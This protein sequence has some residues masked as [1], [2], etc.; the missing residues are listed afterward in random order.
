MGREILE[1]A[2]DSLFVD[3]SHRDFNAADTK[4]LKKTCPYSKQKA[5]R[6]Y[7]TGHRTADLLL[8]QTTEAAT[9]TGV[10]SA[11]F[12]GQKM[13]RA[14]DRQRCGGPGIANS[15]RQSDSKK[16]KDHFNKWRRKKVLFGTVD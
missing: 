14:K 15:P 9:I 3:K 2:G 7:S 11:L 6:N 13:T 10:L 5:C 16:T 1:L 4:L 12:L 8:E